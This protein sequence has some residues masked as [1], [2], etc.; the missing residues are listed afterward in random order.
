MKEL[1]IKSRS[2]MMTRAL[3]ILGV[4]FFALGIIVFIMLLVFEEKPNVMMNIVAFSI[5]GGLSLLS[6]LSIFVS[7]FFCR[8]YDVFSEKGFK[9]IKKSIF[10]KKQKTI[11]EF[12]WE[13]IRIMNYWDEICWEN[14]LL[15]RL[16]VLDIELKKPIIRYALTITCVETR[17]AKKHIEQIKEVTKQDIW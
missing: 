15:C 8:R 7:H 11:Y 1:T 14:I 2:V 5:L 9:R 16:N 4:F 3:I 10:S 17:V 12:L 13:D 6:F